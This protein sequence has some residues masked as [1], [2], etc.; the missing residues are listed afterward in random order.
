MTFFIIYYPNASANSEIQAV[1]YYGLL[2]I[3][4]SSSMI[5]LIE[6]CDLMIL[7]M[8][9]DVSPKFRCFGNAKGSLK[10]TRGR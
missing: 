3:C 5:T 6:P 9:T 4:F 8:L 10:Y 2:I 7:C 1:F